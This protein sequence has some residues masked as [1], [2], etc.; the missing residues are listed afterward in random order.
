[1]N[2]KETTVLI[3]M[4]KMRSGVEKKK[5]AIHDIIKYLR[6][7]PIDEAEK[8]LQ[9]LVQNSGLSLFLFGHILELIHNPKMKYKFVDAN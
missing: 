2:E 7:L 8:D 5:Q 4:Y 9:S 3:E 6:S 1:M